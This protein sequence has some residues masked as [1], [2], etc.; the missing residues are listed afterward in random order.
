MKQNMQSEREKKDKGQLSSILDQLDYRS[1]LKFRFS[2]LLY[3]TIIE[4]KDYGTGES[5]KMLDAHILKDIDENQGILSVDLSKIWCRTRSAICVIIRR[6]EK[7]GYITKKYI[8]EN[9]KER[10]LFTTEKGHRLCELH[11]RYDAMQTSNLIQRM[12]E[13][14]TPEEIDGF[15]RVLEYQIEVMQQ[16][17]QIDDEGN[18]VFAYN[19]EE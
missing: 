13:K 19:S 16:N 10:A 11:R 17:C 7:A 8:G 14:F 3:R 9:K 4:E 6:L 18:V 15:F 12:L 1:N 2:A 5:I